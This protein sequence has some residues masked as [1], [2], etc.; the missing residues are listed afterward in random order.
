MRSAAIALLTVW[1]AASLELIVVLAL[2]W[3]ELTSTWEAKFGALYL[4]PAALLLTAPL[5]LV[6]ALLFHGFV[7]A[8]RAERW[9]STAVAGVAAGS[10]AALVATGRHFAEP[11]RREAFSA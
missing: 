3:A 5:G 9:V 2:H 1:V 4:A 7:G 10:V 11:F 6:A 8:S